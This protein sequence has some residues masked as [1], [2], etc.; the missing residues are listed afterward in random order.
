MRSLKRFLLIRSRPVHY[1]GMPT[2]LEK[3][4]LGVNFLPKTGRED[5]PS[6]EAGLI[7]GINKCI[8]TNDTVIIIGGGL[9]VT[10]T[11]AAK[12]VGPGGKVIFFEG[13]RKCVRRIR[14]TLLRNSIGDNVAVDNVIVGNNIGV[15]G[16]SVAHKF[17][18]PSALPQC[19]VL[20]L[21]CEGSEAEIIQEM[22]IRPR[23]IIVETHGFN[24]SSSPLISAL[25][26]EKGYA[27][28]FLG[29]AE[30]DQEVFCVENDINVILAT[31]QD[32]SL[33]DCSENRT[34]L[35]V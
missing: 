34:D 7:S 25:L 6:Y 22:K 27:I 8:K 12:K 9:G 35:G 15:Y 23:N 5:K 26:K 28:D 18:H 13:G 16:R 14:K 30:P 32:P 1:S 29:V 21:D 2:A 33:P 31:R 4:Y 17:L 3:N 24:G 11:A 20:E 10:V 19:D